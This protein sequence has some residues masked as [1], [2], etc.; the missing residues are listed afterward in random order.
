MGVDIV[1]Y[2]CETC[3][4][5]V[6]EPGTKICPSCKNESLVEINFFCPE[7]DMDMGDPTT[8]DLNTLGWGCSKCNIKVTKGI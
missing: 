1:M 6:I 8:I 3:D 7:C 5:L 4:T 2:K